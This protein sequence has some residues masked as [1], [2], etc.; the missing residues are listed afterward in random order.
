MKILEFGS[1]AGAILTALML[2]ACAS[3]TT[4][5]TTSSTPT[6]E[7]ILSYTHTAD[8]ATYKLDWLEK[9]GT[10]Y[11]VKT[12]Q[13]SL[14]SSGLKSPTFTTNY[15]LL[16]DSSTIGRLLAYKRSDLTL[17]GQLNVGSFPQDMVVVN[18]I[19]YIANGATSTTLLKRVDVSNLPTLTA[20][21]DITVGAQPSVV[22]YWGDKI[23]VGNQ[24]YT[25]KAQATIS[26]INP[27]T[28]TVTNTINTGPNN[29]EIAYDGTRIWTQNVDWYNPGCASGASTLTYAP[30]ATYTPATVTTPAP[31]ATN[32][33]CSK[34]GIGFNSS[35]GFTALRH[36]SGNFHLFS[37]S[38][39]T[40]N[41]TAVDSTNQYKFV[42]SGGTY[43]YKIHN[44]NGST[45]NLTTIVEDMSGSVLT[46]QTLTKDTEMYF[47][48]NK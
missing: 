23:Y 10:T 47:F 48:A 7:I 6:T 46:T 25:L 37:I 22:R 18:N 34:G 38:G 40:L 39:T 44:G 12:N 19:A 4:D 35:G 30:V 2:F 17:A 15:I 45:N 16:V 41:T 26:V 21:S 42:G 31:Y 20:L 9:T 28:N 14:S 5:T 24:D 13:I 33:N 27:T 3:N 11:T 32:S 29:M 36:S 8:Y 1:R 43:L